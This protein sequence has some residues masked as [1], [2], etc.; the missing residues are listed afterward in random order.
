MGLRLFSRKAD[1]RPTAAPSPIATPKPESEAFQP[2]D[3]LPLSRDI[4]E[5]SL[6]TKRFGMF[7]HPPAAWSGHQNFLQ[8]Q[9]RAAEEI[10]DR[11]AL[12]PAGF[13][14]IT[15]RLND[16]P[17]A[18]EEDQ[19]SEP[20][21]LARCAVTNA[22]YQLFVDAGGYSDPDHWPESVWPHLIDFKDLTSAPGPRY[23]RNGRH[24][25][26][27]A[28]HPV[29]GISWYEASA[30]AAWAGYRLPSEAEW[31]VAATW[32][33]SSDAGSSRRYPWGDALDL[34]CC[35]IWA[36]GHG[37]TLAVDAQPLGAAPNGVLGLV[38]NT[39]EWV[40]SDFICSDEQARPIIGEALLKGIRGGA[41][42]T[43][44][45]W[46]ATGRFRTGLP[47]LSRAHNVGFRCA[48]DM[49]K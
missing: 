41:Y 18:P 12:V 2:A 16:E 24:D 47:C 21:L 42:D 34:A 40:E 35:N 4:V 19:H 15:T 44:F 6:Q 46:Q 28:R 43:Y 22:E 32:Q 27:L 23:W 49:G 33:L 11:F 13:T 25:K 8:M 45:P 10:D 1:R 5:Q 29:V 7:L 48:L 20:F 39:W 37:G 17:G 3:V 9:Q 30:Y 26:R 36:S 14:S 38:G 31:Q